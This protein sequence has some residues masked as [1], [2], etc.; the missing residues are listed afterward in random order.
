LSGI[1]QGEPTCIR[2]LNQCLDGCGCHA[3]SIITAQRLRMQR[4]AEA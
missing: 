2:E 1:L 3:E 4:G